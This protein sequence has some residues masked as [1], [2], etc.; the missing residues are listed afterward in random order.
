MRRPALLLLL[1]LSA[2]GGQRRLAP[3][4]GFTSA[5]CDTSCGARAE[6]TY[7]GVGGFLI[8]YGDNAV[9]TAPFF[10][11]RAIYTQ[12]PGWRMRAD[13]KRI[14]SGMERLLPEPARSGIQAILVGHSHFD[15]LMDVPHIA[16]KHLKGDTIRVWGNRA[17]LDLL[18]RHPVR[19]RLEAVD[20]SAETRH[21][22]GRWIYPRAD[23]IVRFMAIESEH[24]PH[25]SGIRIYDRR[26]SL[27]RETLPPTAWRWAEGQPH[28]FL[29]EFR[30]KT[31]EGWN[32]R[33]RVHYQDSAS[34]PPLGF[35]PPR[36]DGSRD[37]LDVAL[38]CAGNFDQ[39]KAYPDSL[40]TATNPRH[41]V[42]GHW[43]DFFARPGGD[44]PR[45]VPTLD[46]A[47]LERRIGDRPH[48]VP[49]PGA[50][51]TFCACPAAPARVS[52][53]AP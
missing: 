30:E 20:D 39:V 22:R 46:L 44:P 13:A 32:V 12:L 3:V 7:L 42:V 45:P 2:C 38:I 50:K 14:D 16:E 10:S 5:A 28:A 35:P 4:P 34:N 31:A 43:E 21:R 51:M 19:P 15:H 23:S 48:V 17:M 6:I 40:L 11:T 24:A 53:S 26:V 41:V 25:L 37:P 52:A 47:E 33:F 18:H 49:N 9:L 36:D 1:V 8:R 27:P 29:I